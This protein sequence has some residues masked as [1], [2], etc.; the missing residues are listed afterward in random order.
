MIIAVEMVPFSIFFHFAYDA[1]AY[2]L[3]KPR[4]LPISEIGGASTSSDEEQNVVHRVDQYRKERH[5]PQQQHFSV[6]SERAQSQTQG[7]FGGPLG[8]NAWISLLNPLEILRAIAFA[9][10]MKSESRGR[11][12]Q[13]AGV[14]PPSYP[15]T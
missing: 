10:R 4:P 9:F 1:G 6:P 13:V 15:S 14:A 7:Y 5:H 8:V 12:R 3:T 2:N 11:T